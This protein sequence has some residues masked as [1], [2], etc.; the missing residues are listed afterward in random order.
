[1]KHNIFYLN[2]P[3]KNKNQGILF[4]NLQQNKNAG[5]SPA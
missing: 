5:E 2:Y 3:N 4:V 1:M